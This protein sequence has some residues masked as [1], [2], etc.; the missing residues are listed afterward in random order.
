MM[1][2]PFYKNNRKKHG[3]QSSLQHLPFRSWK[4]KIEFTVWTIEP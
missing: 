1:L 2:Y 4:E 3:T